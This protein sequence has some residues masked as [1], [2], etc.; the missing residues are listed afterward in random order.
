M[1]N[2]YDLFDP[3]LVSFTLLVGHPSFLLFGSAQVS[4]G[5]RWCFFLSSMIAKAAVAKAASSMVRVLGFM[6]SPALRSRA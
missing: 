2:R 4:R 5:R 3:L 1:D 6:T